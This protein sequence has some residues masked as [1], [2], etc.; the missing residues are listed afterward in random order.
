[1][2]IIVT[3]TDAD[4]ALFKEASKFLV[5]HALSRSVVTDPPGSNITVR[6]DIMS[7]RAKKNL[8]M[9]ILSCYFTEAEMKARNKI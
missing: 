4:E 1:M 5:D 9:A 6:G 8:F 7:N 2:D 3:I